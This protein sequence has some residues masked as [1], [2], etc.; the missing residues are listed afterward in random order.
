MHELRTFILGALPIFEL[1]GAIPYGI[2]VGM[3]LAKVLFY[4]ILG[5]V[6]PIVPVLF[7][8]EPVSN[9][10]R[11]FSLFRKFFDWFS[12]RTKKQASVI[13]KYEAL[14]LAIFVAVPLPGTGAWTGCLA[15]TLFKIRF[16]YALLAIIAGVL[17]AAAIVTPVALLG[18]GLIYKI[19]VG[20]G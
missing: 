1:R 7:L 12:E 3:P 16:R 8:F 15:A 18:K 2:A 4:A 19:F 14:G 20:H 13:E 9:Y 6:V 17:I 5:N 10:L 11:R